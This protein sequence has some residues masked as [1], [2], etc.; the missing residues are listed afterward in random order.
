MGVLA[1]FGAKVNMRKR[2]IR[3][4]PDVMEHVGTEWSN[5]GDWISLKIGDT[6][7]KTEE[8]MFDKFLLRNPKLFSMVI[9]NCVLMRVAVD[10]VSTSGGVEEVGKK[11]SYGLLI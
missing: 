9:D 8:V 7:E 5:K 3:I 10:N 4:D 11:V 1:N 2:T 6:G